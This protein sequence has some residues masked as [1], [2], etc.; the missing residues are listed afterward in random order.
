V[1]EIPE[2]ERRQDAAL[3]LPIALVLNMP[4]FIT[5]SGANRKLDCAWGKENN[6]ESGLSCINAGSSYAQ[7][8]SAEIRRGGRLLRKTDGS[9]YILAGTRRSLALQK[10]DH[11]VIEPGIAELILV[12]DDLKTESKNIEIP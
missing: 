10:I 7:V 1:R 8:R 12:Y 9:T 11:Q 3:Q 5:P 2:A 4:V 6:G